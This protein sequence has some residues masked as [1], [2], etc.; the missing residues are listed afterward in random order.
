MPLEVP[1][2]EKTYTTV[3]DNFKGVDLTNDASNVYKRRSPS[4]KNMLP[5]I[6]GKPYKRPGWEI[7]LTPQDFRDAAG[8]SSDIE[9]CHEKVYY[10]EIGGYDFLMF[11]TTIG[12]FSYTTNPVD[13]SQSAPQKI[14]VYLDTYIDTNN[15]TQSFPPSGSAE[16]DSKRA[17]F[18]E[19][20]G[21]AGFY[22][23]VGMKLFR[24]DGAYLHETVPHV[25]T[26]FINTNYLGVGIAL[27]DVNMLTRERIV[28]YA[29]DGK[30]QVYNLPGGFLSGTHPTVEFLD[31]STGKWV[32][33]TIGTDYTEVQNK[34]RIDFTN[35]AV[36]PASDGRDNLRITYIADG[37]GATATETETFCKE[38]TISV[39]RTRTQQR[40]RR[41]NTG[42]PTA[43]STTKTT[44]SS[45]G[46][47]TFD[48]PN[49]KYNRAE[50]THRAYS[51][52]RRDPSNTG[53]ETMA[54]SFHTD[55][56]GPYNSKVTVAGTKALYNS[57]TPA[58]KTTSK[59]NKAT[60]WRKKS[61]TTNTQYQTRTVTDTKTYRV[62]VRYVKYFYQSGD[63][64]NPSVTAF[65]EC[66]RAA[67]YGTGIINQVFMTSSPK[68][69]YN[70]RV[71]Y[72]AATDPTFFPETN[73][74]EV[75]SNDAP[76]MGLIKCGEYLG[77]IKQG[78]SFDTSIYLAY[79]TS[80]S[81][82]TTYAVKQSVNGIGAISNGAFNTLE[83]EPLF[84]SS[85]G[86]MGIEVS[87]SDTDRQL[88]NRSYFVNKQL[89]EEPML[90]QAI[91]FVFRGMYYLAVNN[92]CYVLDGSQKNSW[93]NT[94]TNLQYEAYYI[95][96][97]PAQC[98]ARMDDD[99]F[100]TD[101]KGNLC[102]FK[103][104]NDANIYRD[105]YST[106]SPD[107]I[108]SSAPVDYRI[109]ITDLAK[110]EETEETPAVNDTVQYGD[111]WYTV[112]ALESDS[113][114][115]E[116]G[117]PI[118]A[119]WSTI[120]DDDGAVH[121]FKNLKKKGC[122]VSLLPASDS[123][124]SVFIKA[125]E[126]D[127]VKIGETDATEYELP[128]DFYTKKKIKKYKRLQFICQNNVL[129]DSFGVDQIVK[130]YTM[131]NYSKNKR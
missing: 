128:F 76:I 51:V 62:R 5:D 115:V 92:H 89:C 102:R 25:P 20:G 36:P 45:G 107:W 123:G 75:G 38:K 18:F 79:P 47:A 67:I 106:G 81:D 97:I 41:G 117:V 26:T 86:V 23:F 43:W 16:I 71:W 35:K 118:D 121:F 84:L 96:N 50:P 87:E 94:K 59:T 104:G 55:T 70:T 98:F 60:S 83:E 2:E 82:I 88:R 39:T 30:Y 33:K 114:V 37:L 3:Y 93:A 111:D 66:T 57:N 109:P 34:G 56:W 100:F 40:T 131:G 80:F 85:E 127:P 124:V 48:T 105:A 65:T 52:Q 31:Q 90:S 74:I 68:E 119:V 14:L 8:V 42:T 108:S 72:S 110:E 63:K 77:V 7:E 46:K 101:F 64:E 95:E 120:A 1:A 29:C 58:S 130:T 103:H 22:V 126:K 54:A 113:A 10:F 15:A 4:G 99:L 44:Y 112:T 116:P 78:V 122:V 69:D 129:D 24:Y 49:I 12:L 19:G 91:S 6:D 21:T 27:E 32:L 125:D 11:F 73:Y 28:T 17:F 61:G 53:W 13:A 9:I